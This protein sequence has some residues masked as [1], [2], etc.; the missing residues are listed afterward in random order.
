MNNDKATTQAP[1]R[2]GRT[3]SAV[4]ILA[5]I[6]AVLGCPEQV[7]GAAFTASGSIGQTFYPAIPPAAPTVGPTR[8]AF[9]QEYKSND[10]VLVSDAEAS[11]GNMALYTL[12]AIRNM[13]NWASGNVTSVASARIFEPVDPFWELW[14]SY[15]ETFN[16]QYQLRVSGSTFASSGGTGAAGSQSS[17]LYSYEVGDSSGGGTM[18]KDSAGHYSQSGTWNGVITNFFTLHKHST[19]D[20]EFVATAAGSGTKT[21]VPWSDTNVLAIGDFSHTLTWM[22]ITGVQAFDSQGNE[23]PLPENA[24]LPLIGRDS[25]FNYWNSAD[26]PAEVPEPATVLLLGS[27]LV[28]AGLMR[29][30]AARRRD[31]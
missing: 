17:L 27:G 20:L 3:R 8:A 12:A 5:L 26:D 9:H 4:P 22:G 16:F 10:I 24:Y 30:S 21:Y 6:L 28:V 25:G 14:A 11:S 15:G 7:P 2:T 23:V 13:Q 31:S 29:K 19:F 18:S 1:A